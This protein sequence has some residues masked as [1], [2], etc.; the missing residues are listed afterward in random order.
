MIVTP[1]KLHESAETNDNN[2]RD[3]TIP[4][5]IFLY[6]EKYIK[7]KQNYHKKNPCFFNQKNTFENREG[8]HRNK[9]YMDH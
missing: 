7:I 8:F 4:I 6:I 3:E 5:T 2:K 1:G 9:I